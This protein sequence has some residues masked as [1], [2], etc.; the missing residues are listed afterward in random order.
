MTLKESENKVNDKCKDYK[1]ELVDIPLDN[2]L[3]NGY[4]NRN[5]IFNFLYCIYYFY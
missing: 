1:S 5:N 2:D 3:N 4:S